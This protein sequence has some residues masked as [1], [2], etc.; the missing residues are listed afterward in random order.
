[1]R[2]EDLLDIVE[3]DRANGFPL[4]MLPRDPACFFW[5]GNGCRIYSARPLACRLYPLGRVFDHGKSHIVLPT[6]NV[7]SGLSASLDATVDQYLQDQDTALHMK[8]AD[9]WI[10]FVSELEQLLLPDKPVTSVAFHLLVYSPDT[11]P[12]PEYHGPV[13]SLEENYYLRLT[14]ARRQL[15]RFLGLKAVHA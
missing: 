15:P 3:T 4:V 14:N 11:P 10:E 2:Y 1:M 6:L 13:D 12:T 5:R 9:F 8:M 7:C